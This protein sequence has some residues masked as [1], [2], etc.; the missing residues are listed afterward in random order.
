MQ[1]LKLLLPISLMALVVLSPAQKTAVATKQ[2][3]KAPNSS[4]GST[5]QVGPPQ[6]VT[7]SYLRMNHS[8]FLASVARQVSEGKLPKTTLDNY[9]GENFSTKLLASNLGALPAPPPAG[10]PKTSTKARTILNGGVYNLLGIPVTVGT[11]DYYPSSIDYDD[12]IPGEEETRSINVMSP[13]DGNVTATISKLPNDFQVLLMESYS[14]LAQNGPNGASEV[15]D[16]QSTNGTLAVTGGQ[17][18]SVV[19]QV[20]SAVSGTFTANLT[21]TCTGNSVNKGQ[22]WTITIPM[23]IVV[24]DSNNYRAEV[25]GKVPKMVAFRNLPFKIQVKVSPINYRGPFTATLATTGDAGLTGNQITLKF[26]SSAAVDA[27]IPCMCPAN[28]KFNEN[29]EMATT[30]TADNG[31][32]TVFHTPVD[33][34]P[35]QVK[36]DYGR[37]WSDFSYIG[38]PPFGSVGSFQMSW[39]HSSVLFDGEGNYALL[40]TVH[41]SF[42]GDWPV[43]DYGAIAPLGVYMADDQGHFHGSYNETSGKTDFIKN[44]WAAFTGGHLKTGIWFAPGYCADQ[45]NYQLPPIDS[46]GNFMAYETSNIPVQHW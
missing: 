42:S 29:A 30:I 24:S 31:Q 40:G 17:N 38:I 13:T 44:N 9:A 11:N 5:G 12:M 27:I 34:A 25:T 41:S 10:A 6:F 22:F 33:I 37:Y 43:S 4:Q 46:H 45:Y 7:P 39:D 32:K 36:C 2:V 1:N 18:F 21:L 14:G 26:N 19:M 16:L 35:L 28:A 20:G 23:K 8:L 3:Q 15:P